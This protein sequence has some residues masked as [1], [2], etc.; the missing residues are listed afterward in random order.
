MSHPVLLHSSGDK[1]ESAKRLY[2]RYW[3]SSLQNALIPPAS[4][5]A[6]GSW[7]HFMK[8]RLHILSPV[9]FANPLVGA[10][11]FPMKSCSAPEW[12]D[13]YPLLKS[14]PVLWVSTNSS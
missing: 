11:T 10:K 14:Y 6:W 12:D 7:S 8:D 13:W 5:Y 3:Q 9:E 1:S 4:F 2:Y